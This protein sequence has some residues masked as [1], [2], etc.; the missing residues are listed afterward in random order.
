MRSYLDQLGLWACLWGN[1]M[2]VEARRATLDAG[3]TISRAEP[4]PA[5]DEGAGQARMWLSSLLWTV[6][7][8]AA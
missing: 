7:R 2:I 1:V 4:W 5:E 8:L 3:G 6:M